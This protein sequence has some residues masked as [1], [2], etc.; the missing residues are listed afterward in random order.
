MG[1]D[2]RLNVMDAR[3][4][5]AEFERMVGGPGVPG[6]WEEKGCP[7]CG[8]KVCLTTYCPGKNVLD[9]NPQQCPIVGEHL[10]RDCHQ[11][12]GGCGFPT[13]ERCKDF[14]PEAVVPPLPV[15]E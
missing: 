8:C 12:A 9:D 7:K 11:P 3:R 6:T 14:D 5:Q 10:H 15:L 2:A 1:R 4:R 13:V